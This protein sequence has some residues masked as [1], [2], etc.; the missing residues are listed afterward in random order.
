MPAAKNPLDQT[1]TE[2]LFL[3]EDATV[4]LRLMRGLIHMV[5]GTS[6]TLFRKPFFGLRECEAL[7]K[8][9]DM[10]TDMDLV[11]ALLALKGGTALEAHGIDHIP[12]TGPALIASTHPTGPF[13]FVAHAGALI[14]RRPDLKVVANNDA[15]TFLGADRIVSVRVNRHNRALSARR[16]VT[17]METHLRDG[18]ALL[19]F[20]SGRVPRRAGSGLIEPHWR[21]G[22][23]RVSKT[24]NI[25]I[26][27]ASIDV[28]NSRYYYRLRHLAWRL[29]GSD[30]FAVTVGSLRY[31][32]EMLDQLGGR[33]DLHYGAPLA[34]GTAPELIQKQAESLVP[35][36]Y[37]GT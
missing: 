1:L 28:R 17:A 24:C 7:W 2:R 30:N 11:A 19:I 32:I 4:R 27:P 23:T 6:R 12:E 10:A 5:D 35:G 22:A 36:L 15:R 16:T 37:Y 34:A 26:I 21:S 8:E 20:G 13:D 18:G 9:L 29:S 25:P 33:Y 14:K 3:P 31:L